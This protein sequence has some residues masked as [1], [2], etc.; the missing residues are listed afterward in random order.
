MKIGETARLA[1]TAWAIE[2]NA[3]FRPIAQDREV[4]RFINGGEPWIDDFVT[5]WIGK[6]VGQQIA[7]GYCMWAL[8][9]KPD[10]C[11]VGFCGLQRLPENPEDTEIGWWLA[12]DKWGQGLATEAARFVL[13]FGF[14]SAGLR[15]IVAKV[16]AANSRSLRVIEKLGFVFDRSLRAGPGGE[17]VLYA[18]TAG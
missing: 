14:E 12:R 1:L 13:A 18:M 6:Q 9:E 10:G 4:M 7:L 17:V 11:L 8:R 5:F 15:R 3:A 2:D 16:N